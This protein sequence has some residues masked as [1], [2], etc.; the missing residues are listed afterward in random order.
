MLNALFLTSCVPTR[1]Q[2]EL[3][4]VQE[5]Q[6]INPKAEYVKIHMHDGGVY[7]FHQWTINEKEEL[8]FGVGGYYN[9]N[10]NKISGN[11]MG[12]EPFP[13]SFGDIALIETNQAQ[14][15][16]PGGVAA[17]SIFSI[18]TTIF[19]IA[20]LADPKACFGSCP[21]YYI[22]KNGEYK[23]QAEGFSS[24]IA[25]VF[26]K[27]DIDRIHMESL[28]RQ[29]INLQ[30]K[31][32]ALETHVIRF[33]DLLAYP[34]ENN[35]DVY[36]GINGKFYTV[37]SVYSP[38]HCLAQEG[39]IRELVTGMDDQERFSLS[40]SLNLVKK[41]D[42][43]ITFNG[44]EEGRY[45]LLIGSRQTL[46]TTFLFYQALA[47]LGHSS[48][49]HFARLETGN[50]RT[51]K[52]VTRMFE[53]LGGIDVY[54]E[55]DKGRW[56]YVARNM[57]MGP[58]ASDVN[59]IE[60]PDILND[61]ISIRLKLTQGL[62]RINYLAL[63]RISDEVDP[64]RIRPEKVIHMNQPD[65]NALVSLL[66]M[67]KSLVT[68]PRDEYYV[69]Y[70]VPDPGLEYRFFIESRGYYYEWMRESWYEE[71]DPGKYHTMFLFPRYF[72]RKI[73]PE[74]KQRELAMEEV[75][76]NSRYIQEN[77]TN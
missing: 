46:L 73:A 41:E 13:V 40:D 61:S 53:I 71:E 14:R 12:D 65:T 60:L 36:S 62:W 4:A 55:D 15:N 54:L 28:P 59:M 29:R 48:S 74:Y 52:L 34:L 30:I 3:I 35:N 7:V 47:Y 44:I 45:G 75:F 5:A 33:V 69:S 39:S 10:R 68:F 9:A 67:D 25:P 16:T 57:E 18:P 32:E 23:L 19:S 77:A 51:K 72:Y 2:R 24:S 1:L 21:T 20:C 8:I 70:E 22:E 31:N 17:F 42:I 64:I 38:D 49:F 26:E 43:E 56:N 50:K 76:W 27:T 58:I 37:D 63:A 66:D 11:Q 6:Q